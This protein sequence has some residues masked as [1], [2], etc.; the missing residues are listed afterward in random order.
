MVFGGDCAGEVTGEA[1]GL[2]DGAHLSEEER[3][4]ERGGARLT[5]G[6]GGEGGPKL[7]QPR[8][9]RIF[10]FS[11]YFLFSFFLNS[12]FSFIQIFIYVT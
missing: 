1:K 7:G 2:T 10:P 9:G 6:G 5:R 12:L 8:G 4:R 3:T 11:F